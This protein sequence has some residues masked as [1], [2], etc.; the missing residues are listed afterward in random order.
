MTCVIGY[1]TDDGIWIGADSAGTDGFGG[2]TM[3]ADTKVFTNGP[4]LFGFC[5]SFRMGQLLRYAL[6]P[7][8]QP[9]GVSDF[10]Y[11]VTTFID[12]VRSVLKKGGYTYI[13]NNE[14]VGGDF[15]VAYKDKLYHVEED[16]QVGL[17]TRS[18]VAIGSGADVAHGAM[19][20]SAE[21]DPVKKIKAA[22]KASSEHNAYV[23]PPFVVRKHK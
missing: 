11:M 12:E 6:T 18:Y 23:A 17:S 19:A 20:V 5:G 8:P 1:H 2:R 9:E 15:I 4:M 10:Q 7:P 3:R 21:E 16:F 22:L 13:K 14:E